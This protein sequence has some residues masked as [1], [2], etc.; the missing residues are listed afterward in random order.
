M[1]FVKE[2]LRKKSKINKTDADNNQRGLSENEAVACLCQILEWEE[3]VCEGY[4]R[5]LLGPLELSLSRFRG[6]AY[7]NVFMLPTS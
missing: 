4:Y 7:S 5:S 1:T 3:V 6:R 2:L